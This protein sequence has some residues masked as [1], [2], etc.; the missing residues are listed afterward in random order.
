MLRWRMLRHGAH[1]VNISA[2]SGCSVRCTSTRPRLMMR[3]RSARSSGSCP[4]ARGLRSFGCTSMSVRATLRS[5]HSTSGCPAACE[6]R[7]VGVHAPRGT[8]SSPRSPCRRSARR[9]TPRCTSAS[10]AVTMRCSK[11]NGGWRNAGDSRQRRLA[12]VQPDARVA[13]AAVPV[14]TSSP[15]CRQSHSGS[16]SSE[17]LISCRHSTSGCSRSSRS[18][19]SRLAGADAVH[20]PGG[21]LHHW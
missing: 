19:T 21:D 13:L 12:D 9:S 1:H 7:R 20:V 11:S 16:W 5:P 17:A 15:R 14:A 6:L 18:C 8:A 3:S 2:L 10:V 4:V